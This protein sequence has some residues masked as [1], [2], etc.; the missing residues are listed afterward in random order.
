MAV[1]KVTKTKRTDKTA[2]NHPYPL[3]RKTT[4]TTRTNSLQ[5][6]SVFEEMNFQ[7]S[8]RNEVSHFYLAISILLHL[9]S[10]TNKNDFTKIGKIKPR[11]LLMPSDWCNS[12]LFIR[13]CGKYVQSVEDFVFKKV[14]IRLIPLE[15]VIFLA[16]IGSVLRKN[17]QEVLPD[18]FW[19]WTAWIE[20]GE[21]SLAA[22]INR[23]VRVV[24]FDN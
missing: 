3:A 14:K 11:D 17:G 18:F 2:W 21:A 9:P 16:V 5:T 6:K 10:S 1:L 19:F 4:M 22:V 23:V 13:W 7:Q 8:R 15:T 24:L 12:V 20:N